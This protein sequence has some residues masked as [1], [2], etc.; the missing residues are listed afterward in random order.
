MLVPIRAWWP[1]S[2]NGDGSTHRLRA[3]GTL[4]RP[5]LAPL[6]R[7]SRSQRVVARAEHLPKGANPRFFV[8]SPAADRID[9]RPLL[10]GLSH[11]LSEPLLPLRRCGDNQPP[12]LGE[13]GVGRRQGGGQRCASVRLGPS[14]ETHTRKV[15]MMRQAGL[16]LA[17]SVLLAGCT[18][19]PTGD[20]V[21]MHPA[22]SEAPATPFVRPANH[23]KSEVAPAAGGHGSGS[24]EHSGHHAGTM[25]HG[26]SRSFA[27]GGDVIADPDARP[28]AEQ[29]ADADPGAKPSGTGT[30]HSVDA[31]R[32]VVN[33]THEPIPAIGWPAMT[34]DLSVAPSVDLSA[35]APGSE[36]TFTLERAA[37]G[38]YVIDSL[39]VSS[40]G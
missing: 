3:V 25:G 30:I 20:Q 23:L 24:G 34:M 7:W 37:D 40:G 12:G 33:L 10:R 8:T 16:L 5:R 28:A 17:T 4:P 32:G 11:L 21:A 36:V 39:E 9:A 1:P 14:R 22:N 15:I 19:G 2:S 31:E 18:P 29:M 38:L 13:A 35:V 27:P 6:D 26:G